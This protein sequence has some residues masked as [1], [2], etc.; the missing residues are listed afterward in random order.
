MIFSS[1]GLL[2]GIRMPLYAGEGGGAGGGSGAGAGA[3]AGGG[4]GAGSGAGAGTGSGTGTGNVTPQNQPGSGGTPNS[5][6][7][8]SDWDDNRQFRFKG[9]EKPISA[10]D[11]VRGF[12]SQFTKASQELAKVKKEHAASQQ[13]LQRIR[14]AAGGGQPGEPGGDQHGS[15]MLQEIA[16]QPFIDGKTMASVVKDFQVGIR[17]RDMVMLA[18]LN[19]LKQIEGVLGEL[20]GTSLNSKHE[21]KLKGWLAEGGYPDD[22]D[23]YEL[24]DI[25]YRGYE[26]NNLDDEFPQIFEQRYKQ[27]QNAIQ[28]RVARDRDRSRSLPWVPGKGG[29]AG[30]GKA[31]G[32]SGKESPKQL[33]DIFFT[34]FNGQSDT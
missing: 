23:T 2:G 1:V 3:G 5:A 4:A 25:I 17:E 12:Q 22:Q 31:Q 18:A 33:A 28:R 27:M 24:A 15:Q 16:S 29:N 7:E 14:A 21:T 26:G 19:K 11:Y 20:H 9:Q 32:L 6:P 10:K 34:R 13:E 8:V 30:P